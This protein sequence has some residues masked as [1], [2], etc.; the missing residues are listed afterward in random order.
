[1]QAG[2]QSQQ[3]GRSFLR[4]WI[5]ACVG[6]T[7]LL[8]CIT[9]GMAHAADAPK[10]DSKLC[11]ALVRHTPDA[12][13]AYQPGVDVEGHA[14]APADLPGQ[15]QMKLPA[16]IT[17]LLT[18]NLA[19]AINLDTSTYPYNQLG[20][21]TEANIGTLTVEGDKVSFNG[22]PLTDRQQ[23]NLAVLCMQPK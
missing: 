14:V 22:Q 2:I 9:A 18:I 17:I 19:K 3:G 21:G 10:P 1:A 13:V 15:P 6:M 4:P 20:A 8:F 11:Q 23:D 7:A 5:P 16:K 12:D